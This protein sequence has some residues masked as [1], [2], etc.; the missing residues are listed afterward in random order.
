MTITVTSLSNGT[1]RNYFVFGARGTQGRPIARALQAAGA[2][3]STITR[4]QDSAA[5]LATDGINA[6]VAPL[7]HTAAVAQTLVGVNGAF[8][9]VPTTGGEEH[10]LTSLRNST[11]VPA[12]LS[13]SGILPPVGDG[14]F[15]GVTHLARAVLA[16]RLQVCVLRPTMFLEDIVDTCPLNEVRVTGV[17]RYPLPIDVPIRWV[18]A[19][20][21]GQHAAERL[22][23]QRIH[24]GRIAVLGDPYTVQDIAL[25]LSALMKREIRAKHWPL[26]EYAASIATRV[27]RPA[28]DATAAVYACIAR[29]IEQL[30]HAAAGEMEHLLGDCVRPWLKTLD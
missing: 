5:A 25:R 12:V 10:I 15:A 3:V 29:N 22:L 14:P 11:S 6:M 20:A 13:T 19:S 2:S 1:R 9:H 27:G 26:D 17:L 21:I 7:S 23:T 28:A 24:A 18:T 16:E 30:Q 8:W 4:A